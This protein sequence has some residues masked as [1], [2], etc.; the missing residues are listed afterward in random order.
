MVDVMKVGG[1]GGG[2]DEGG[3]GGERVRTLNMSQNG[4]VADK[5]KEQLQSPSVPFGSNMVK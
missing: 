3:G 4:Q 5:K 2:R 1:G